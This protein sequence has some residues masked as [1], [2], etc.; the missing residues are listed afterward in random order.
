[1][2]PFHFLWTVFFSLF[3]FAT[4][5]CAFQSP[6]VGEGGRGGQ[7]PQVDTAFYSSLS[8]RCIGPF[9]GGRSCA[10]VGHPQRESVFYFGATGGGVWRSLDGGRSWENISDGFFGGSIGAIAISE[11]DPNVL[12]VGQ[13]EQT[14]RGNVSSGRGLW[15]SEDAGKSWR[16]IGLSESRHIARIRIHPRD[17]D[18]VY[19]AV[20][21]D[22]FTSSEERG[23][24]RSKDGGKTWERILYVDADVGAADLILDPNN[25]RIIYAS[26]WRV[27]R[28]PYSFSSGGEG[29]G[30]W[31]S[32]D[33]GD[34]WVELSGKPGLPK[35]PLGIIGIAVSPANS[36]RLWAQVEAPEGGLFR[37]DD[38]GEHWQKVN[39]ERKMRQRA[40]YYTRVYADPLDEDVV[41]VLNVRWYKSKDGGRHF[42]TMGSPHGDH[43]DLWI[44]PHKPRRM[45]IAD[46][47]GAQVSFDG[48]ENWSTYHNQPTAQFYRLTTDDVFPFRVYAAQQD[49]SSVRIAHRSSGWWITERDWEPTAGCECGHLAPD[50]ANPDIVYGGC[51][52][53]YLE[54]KDHR[55]AM[56]RNISVWPDLPMGYGAESLKYRFNWNFPIL[57]SRHYSGR[58]YAASNHLHRS[59]DGG[60]SWQL[61]SPDLTRNDSTK[62]GPSG[63]PITKDNTS[64]EYY[65]TIFAVAESAVQAGVIWTGSDDGLIYLTRD[66]GVH[67]ENVT[68]PDLPAWIQINSLEAD[69][70]HEGGLYVAATAYK[71]GDYRPYL[72]KTEDYGRSW[73]LI[74]KGIGEEDFTRVI[75]ADPERQGLLYAGTERAVYVSFDDGASWAS[76][77]LNLPEVPITDLAVKD[78]HLIAATQGRSLWVLD[79][80]ILLQQLSPNVSKQEIHFFKPEAPYRMEGG[81]A[82]RSSLKNGVNEAN[83]LRLHF[84]L[85]NWQE[86]D[87]LVFRFLD[88]EGKAIRTFSSQPEEG[89]DPIGDLERGANF[90]LWDLRYAKAKDFPGM[91]FWWGSLQGPKVVP[92]RYQLRWIYRPVEGERKQGQLSFEVKQDPRSPASPREMEQQLHFALEVLDK[93]SEAHEAILEMRDLRE[94]LRHYTSRLEA[95]EGMGELLEL[96]EQIDSSLLELEKELYQTK[97]RSAQD[98]LNYPVRLTNK[99]AHL[100]AIMSAD[101]PP[102]EQAIAVKNELSRAVDDVLAAFRQIKERDLQNFNR[103]MR[104]K[105]VDAVI[106]R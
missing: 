29:S 14:L 82:G 73:R 87:T 99:L 47:G 59:T 13:G 4:S 39:D 60:Q 101:Y 52:G 65:C 2:K 61:I 41:Y 15:K 98:P 37:S 86:K 48:G 23:V 43:H 44:D 11:Y 49:N 63:G 97:N 100:N 58:L 83:G 6:I 57:F 76:L 32:T 103:L 12:Y 96:A 94:Q 75:R 78:N 16:H 34:H 51:Y 55:R 91:I 28:T 42:K 106:L 17:P 5:A 40:W 53:G 30:L 25:P 88:T 7:T 35:G 105:Q 8:W 56:S 64:V 69:P 10:V 80:L 26:T 102:T 67:W 66:D 90:F 45:I 27:R 93:V 3:F 22:L 89:E 33:G 74:V 54:R 70:F 36:D 31:K 68:P 1:M 46:D 21:G 20:I 50:P 95:K 9:R 84:F 71:S 92:G 104:E 72:Y 62:L 24:Y 38:G 79:D 77:Q 85:P 81:Q 19:V 18:W